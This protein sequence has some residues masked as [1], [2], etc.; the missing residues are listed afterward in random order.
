MKKM[1]GKVSTGW[2]AQTNAFARHEAGF[3]VDKVGNG[4]YELD[5]SLKPMKAPKVEPPKVKK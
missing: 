5:A 2:T 3:K 4:R 1:F